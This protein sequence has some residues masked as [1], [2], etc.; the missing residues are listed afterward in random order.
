M[1]GRLVGTIRRNHALE[2]ATISVLLGRLGRDVRM[3]GRAT[4]DGFWVYGNVS[5]E[6]LQASSAEALARLQRGESHLAVSPLC[7][8]NLAVGGLL[9]GL[10]ATLA[11][12]RSDGRL[13]RL[14]N[15]LMV[16]TLSM[17]ASQPLGRLVQKHLTTHPDLSQTEILGVRGSGLVH[18]VETS[19]GRPAS[20]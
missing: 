9:A 13:Q 5:A 3:V 8:T 15:V 10:S 19:R 4:G 18:K 2:H 20:P 16:S 11:L 14:P 12:G 6:E 17:L 1:L 7:G